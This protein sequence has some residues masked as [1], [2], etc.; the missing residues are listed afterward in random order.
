M[1]VDSLTLSARDLDWRQNPL[2]YYFEPLLLLLFTLQGTFL[3]TSPGPISAADQ[4]L[5][6]NAPLQY[7]STGDHKQLIVVNKDT[8]QVAATK[9]LIAELD[10][11]V[12]I[13]LKVSD[14]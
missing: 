11:S 2:F 1:T 9:Q 4:D 3:T 12:T 5:G 14:T 8:G 10:P 13:V 7:S 6:I